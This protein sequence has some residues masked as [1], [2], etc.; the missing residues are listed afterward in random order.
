MLVLNWQL[1]G[2][3]RK[4]IKQ[5]ERSNHYGYNYGRSCRSIKHTRRFMARIL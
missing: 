5:P 3:I 1:N 4:N 2:A